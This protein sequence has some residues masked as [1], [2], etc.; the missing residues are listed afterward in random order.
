MSE[1]HYYLHPMVLI[2]LGEVLQL[3]YSTFRLS[4]EIIPTQTPRT[5]P[6]VET[7]GF[8]VSP[9]EPLHVGQVVRT[10][11]SASLE[12]RKRVGHY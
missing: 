6:G 2:I 4:V 11:V 12:A 9:Q 1:N 7:F 10:K 8:K 3:V 5:L